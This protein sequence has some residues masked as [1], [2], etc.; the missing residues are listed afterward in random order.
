[1]WPENWPALGAFLKLQ[2]QW[3]RNPATGDLVALDYPA[4]Q[5]LLWAGGHEGA[6]RTQLF[7][8]LV[9]MEH[10]ALEAWHEH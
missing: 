9:D 2:T 5:A 7:D 10:G 3:R 8:A 4:V 6:A 1:M